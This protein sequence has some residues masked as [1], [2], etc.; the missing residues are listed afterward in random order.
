[1]NYG[2]V[3]VRVR[4]VSAAS[5][6]GTERPTARAQ[7]VALGLGPSYSHHRTTERERGREERE[8]EIERWD[9]RRRDE[10]ART[11]RVRV[12][13]LVRARVRGGRAVVSLL[14]SLLSLSLVS[15]VACGWGGDRGIG[16]C[17][18][19]LGGMRKPPA[20][21]PTFHLCVTPAGSVPCGLPCVCVATC[22]GPV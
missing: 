21:V 12:R 10:R 1:M 3:C 20:A 14:L 18:R 11:Q 22:S 9:S 7:R 15:L 13:P 2:Q 5:P 19:C 17:A 16:A 4:S 8:S 6:V